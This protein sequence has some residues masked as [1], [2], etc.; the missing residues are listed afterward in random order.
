[1]RIIMM[2]VHR[3]KEIYM[4]RVMDILEENRRFAFGVKY[5]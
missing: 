5:S 3:G 1:M 2:H 4:V